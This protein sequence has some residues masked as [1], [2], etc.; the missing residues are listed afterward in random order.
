MRNRD[1]AEY[2]YNSQTKGLFCLE[3]E[4]FDCALIVDSRWK[5]IQ[6]WK[7]VVMEICTSVHIYQLLQLP[8]PGQTSWRERQV[9]ANST[10]NIRNDPHPYYVK[11]TEV[12]ISKH[13]GWALLSVST[14]QVAFGHMT[15]VFARSISIVSYKKLLQRFLIVKH[16]PCSL[17][18]VQ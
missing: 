1:L 10:A 6:G 4:T 18:K 2:F 8:R 14:P 3:Q 12:N 5:K 7:Y 16:K 17:Q 11:E 13:M 9:Q 15:F